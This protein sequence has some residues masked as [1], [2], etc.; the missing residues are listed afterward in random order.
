MKELQIYEKEYTYYALVDSRGNYTIC[1]AGEESDLCTGF[2]QDGTWIPV[3]FADA[4]KW[5][6]EQIEESE[7]MEPDDYDTEERD[8]RVN[9]KREKEQK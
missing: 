6:Q 9:V 1:A 2:R 5:L 4:P 7:S 3:K 8:I